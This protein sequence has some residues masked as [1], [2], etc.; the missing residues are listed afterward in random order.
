MDRTTNEQLGKSFFERTHGSAKE[1]VLLNAC[2]ID[3]EDYYQV[4]AFERIVDRSQWNGFDSRVVASTRRI[5]EIL[6]RRSTRA[7]FF[8]LG[9][10]AEREPKLVREIADAGHEIGCHSHLHRLVYSLDR[11]SFRMDL[12]ESK[13]ALEQATG[14]PVR[15][16]RAPSFSITHRSVW[17]LEVLIEEGFLHDSSIFPICHDRYGIPSAPTG[18]FVVQTASGNITEFPPTIYKAWKWNVP[19]AGGGYFRLYP[20]QITKQFAKAVN[21]DGRPVNLYLHPWE[22]DPDQPRMGGISAL[23]RF[24]HY[25]NLRSTARK[26]S[27]FLS[28]ASFDT[29]SA[30]L[31]AAS[32]AGLPKLRVVEGRTKPFEPVRADVGHHPKPKRL[33]RAFQKPSRELPETAAA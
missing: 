21:R 5:L 12:R 15:S 28:H 32:A 22:F 17:A 19:V 14:K 31:A 2:T 10:V 11:E 3:V 16:Y 24:R 26:F 30:S 4:S 6:D 7:T 27:R 18:P 13:D 9:W 33:A 20:Y 1:T 29:M 8:T 25:V 23:T